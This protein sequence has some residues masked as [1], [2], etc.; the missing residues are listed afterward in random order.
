MPNKVLLAARDKV[1]VQPEQSLSIFIRGQTSLQNLLDAPAFYCRG[2]N[3][4]MIGASME[5]KVVPYCETIRAICPRHDDRF[6]EEQLRF[7]AS[8]PHI[9]TTAEIND[10]R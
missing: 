2:Q 9:G 4:A 10:G 7:Q 3:Q 5:P 1:A 6:V 8:A